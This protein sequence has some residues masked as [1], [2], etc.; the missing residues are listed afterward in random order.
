MY[1]SDIYTVSKN[2]IFLNNVRRFQFENSLAVALDFQHNKFCNWYEGFS[3]FTPS[4]NNCLEAFNNIIKRDYVFYNR[5]HFLE[6]INIFIDIIN[7]YFNKY[8]IINNGVS[9]KK[10]A[11]N[12][13]YTVEKI[14]ALN[15]KR[16]PFKTVVKILP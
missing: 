14:L 6:L 3:D 9:E 15:F 11:I 2:A 4:T 12:L 5:K 10:F 13:I 1:I 16:G 8:N 7:I